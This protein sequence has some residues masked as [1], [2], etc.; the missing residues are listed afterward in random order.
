[1]VCFWPT[2][3]PLYNDQADADAAEQA[4]NSTHGPFLERITAAINA[5]L[6]PHLKPEKLIEIPANPEQMTRGDLDTLVRPL[7]DGFPAVE[8][9][10]KKKW[11]LSRFRRS[12]VDKHLGHLGC[13]EPRTA[14]V[15]LMVRKPRT[16]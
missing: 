12:R 15:L 9:T 3:H 5:L 16:T 1:M 14:Q 2:Q 6:R 4:F 13:R 8:L 7:A 10:G 11:L